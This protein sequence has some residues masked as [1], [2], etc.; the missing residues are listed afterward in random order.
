M[1]KEFE[2]AGWEYS[3]DLGPP[4]SAYSSLYKWVGEG[5]PI[6]PETKLRKKD[7]EI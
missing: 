6:I 7:E 5:E 2:A 3:D 4:H 1:A